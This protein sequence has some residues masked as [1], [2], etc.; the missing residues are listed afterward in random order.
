[1]RKDE[2]DPNDWQEGIRQVREYLW[3]WHNDAKYAFSQM[4]HPERQRMPGYE[5]KKKPVT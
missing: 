4:A 1:M 3:P 2:H 5:E